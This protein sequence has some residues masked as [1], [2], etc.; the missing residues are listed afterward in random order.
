[1]EDTLSYPEG[2]AGRLMERQ[3]VA[4][5]ADVSLDV[6]KRYLHQRG[7]LPR[8]TTALMVVDRQGTFLGKLPLE[9][10]LTKDPEMTVSE[11]MDAE[12][13]SIN[14]LT[15]LSEVSHLFQRRDLVALPV[16]DDNHKLLG[17]RLVGRDPSAG[18]RAD[19]LATAL[20]AGMSV[21][22]IADPHPRQPLD[23][24]LR[25]VHRLGVTLRADRVALGVE[26]LAPELAEGE[27]LI[28]HLA[29]RRGVEVETTVLGRGREPRGR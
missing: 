25:V 10:L 4:V 6:I 7:T 23:R 16:V 19:V 26:G 18:K 28:E 13:V 9:L 3:L 5:R 8:R 2:S 24:R 14:V 22:Q 12:A 1:M 27:E 29:L 15:P 20:S 21:E 11:L 17:A